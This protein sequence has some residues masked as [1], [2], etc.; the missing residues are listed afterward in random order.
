MVEENSKGSLLR[1]LLPRY[2]VHGLLFSIFGLII[3]I[4]LGVILLGLVVFAAL[5]GLI[6]G[7]LILFLVLG[8][9]NKFLMDSIWS[10]QVNDDW[11]SLLVHGFALAIAF[12]V[13]SIPSFIIR[14]YAASLPTTIVL[15]IIYCFIDGYVA[16]AVGSY[17]IVSRATGRTLIQLG[18]TGTLFVI[19]I[20]V[21]AG[22]GFAI[23]L[24][25]LVWS[26]LGGLLPEF[27]LYLTGLSGLVT[28]LG[29]IILSL[30]K[31]EIQQE[32]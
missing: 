26:L 17:W 8:A 3:G 1:Y 24:L 5:I 28:L 32:D 15:F 25:L 9:V 14:L 10:I 2:F 16:K 4:V 21:L 13:V 18:F 6:I 27:L 19:L 20:T 7:F 29:I 11:E 31:G 12:L 22:T 23:G 30:S